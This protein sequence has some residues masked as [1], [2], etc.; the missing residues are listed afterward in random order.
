MLHGECAPQGA[1]S[2][3]QE[4]WSANP[5]D[6][7]KGR[8]RGG[9]NPS[10]WGQHLPGLIPSSRNRTDLLALPDVLKEG[11]KIIHCPPLSLHWAPP[12]IP[13]KILAAEV[14]V[15]FGLRYGSGK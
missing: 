12:L 14:Q 11:I 10:T 3:C 1:S 4:G 6:E 7:W 15:F 9:P 8:L 13:E 2:S 5:K